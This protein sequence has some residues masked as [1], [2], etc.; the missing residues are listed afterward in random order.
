MSIVRIDSG[1]G[2]N[3]EHIAIIVVVDLVPIQCHFR[4]RRPQ[5]QPN[6]RRPQA[7]G[8]T[9]TGLGRNQ[10]LGPTQC[11]GSEL[12]SSALRTSVTDGKVNAEQP[13]RS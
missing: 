12:R 9:A 1:G 2:R 13:H 11:I 10:C 7:R 5:A 6:S 4:S 3:A 8:I